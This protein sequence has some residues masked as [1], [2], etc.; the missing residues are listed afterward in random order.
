MP[1]RPPALTVLYLALTVLY[2]VVTVLYSY[3][4]NTGAV[5]RSREEGEG[6]GAGVHLTVLYM[7][8]TVLHMALTV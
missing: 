6:H 4:P 8:L 7:A 2:M 5:G 1:A 3:P